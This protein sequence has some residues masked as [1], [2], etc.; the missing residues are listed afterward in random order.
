[1]PIKT[2]ETD[3]KILALSWSRKDK[4]GAVSHQTLNFVD[5]KLATEDAE[6][7][8]FIESLPT[9]KDGTINEYTKEEAAAEAEA[10]AKSLRAAADAAVALAVEAEAAWKALLPAKVPAK[11]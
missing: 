4:F 9:F 3:R 6:V 10:K 1:M 8:S 11:A 7:Q 5:G 2:Y